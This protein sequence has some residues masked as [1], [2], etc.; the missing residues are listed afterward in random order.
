MYQIDGNIINLDM[1]IIM[2]LL[3]IHII[4]VVGCT[5]EHATNYII[6]LVT[7]FIE[8]FNAM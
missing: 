5:Y 1:Q 2:L 8:I 7:L 4:I 3:I 6:I